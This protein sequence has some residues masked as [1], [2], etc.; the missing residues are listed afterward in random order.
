MYKA[1]EEAIYRSYGAD[2]DIYWL[3][4]KLMGLD[5]AS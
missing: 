2:V 5:L 3:E 1:Y 4:D